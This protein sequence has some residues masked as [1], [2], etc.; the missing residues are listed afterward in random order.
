MLG[1]LFV[2]FSRGAWLG[3]AAAALALAFAL[4]RRNWQGLALVAAG[5]L[6]A[7]GLALAGL[8]PASI[9]SRLGDLTDFTTVEDVRGVEIRTD[10]FAIVERLAHWQAAAGMVRDYPWLGVGLGNYGP[11]Y[12]RYALVNWPNALGHAHMIYL[13]VLAET[14]VLGLAAYLLLWGSVVVL[15][16]R[17][18]QRTIGL[19]RGLALGLLGTWAHLSVHQLVDSLY[20]NNI[21]F[22][23]A[24]LLALLVVLSRWGAARRDDVANL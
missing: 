2:S 23:L 13:N 7:G 10:N 11:V 16:M 14:G 8:L 24:G 22:L 18:L 1:G 21:H 3:A 17:V 15:N 19:A 9:T 5:G 12:P 20:V 6:A 4:P